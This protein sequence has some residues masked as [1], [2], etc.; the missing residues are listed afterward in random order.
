M[1]R[2][3]NI[4]IVVL[5]LN[6]TCSE[7]QAQ[8]IELPYNQLTLLGNLEIAPQHSLTD[9]VILMTHAGLGHKAMETMVTLQS[10]LREQGYNSLAI[11]LSLGIDKRRGML[12]CKSTHRH[13]YAD[14]VK[15]IDAW[16]S[17]LKQKAVNKVILL[18]HS[19]GGS[20]TAYYAAEHERAEI[21]AVVLLAPDTLETNSAQVY[22]RRYHKSLQNVLSQAKALVNAKQGNHV[23]QH[24]DFL[25]CSDTSVSAA[26]FNSYYGNDPHLDSNLLI[27]NI[28][29]PTLIILAG[30]DSIVINNDKHRALASLKNV[31]VDEVEAAGHFFRDLNADEAVDK[32]TR[33]IGK[34]KH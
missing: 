24:T 33:F 1:T 32:I 2:L 9:G 26:T 14:A 8:E 17:W 3:F 12:D 15:E 30:Q 19:R 4:G 23:M 5:L 13:R 18:G 11:T 28:A 20:Q 22:Q 10:L 27:R 6:S 25:Y 31:Q 29:K 7:G 16:I 34:L 21:K